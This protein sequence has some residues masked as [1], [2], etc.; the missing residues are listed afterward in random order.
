MTSVLYIASRQGGPNSG[1]WGPVG[2]LEHQDGI[3]R[4][5]YTRGAQSLQG[6]E[7]F[8]GMPALDRVYESDSLFPLFA[9]RLPS[10]SRPEYEAYLAW[11]GFDSDNPPDPLALLGVTQGLRQTDSLEVF[12]CP[13]R[14]QQGR[15]LSK[16]FLHGVRWMHPAAQERIAHLRHG[17]ALRLFLEVGNPA[18]PHAVQLQTTDIRGRLPVGYVPRYLALD[19]RELC[20]RCHPDLIEVTVERLNAGAPLQQRVLCRMNSCW[21]DNFMPCTSEHFQPIV[22]KPSVNGTPQHHGGGRE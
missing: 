18:D 2:R 11:G 5:V 13:E 8:P 19:V 1:F 20:E 10:P 15:Y 7:P 21:P 22:A 9:N 16:F 12:P 3:Y 6:F 17:E 14:D 4:F